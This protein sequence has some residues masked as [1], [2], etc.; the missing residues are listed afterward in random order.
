MKSPASPA[1]PDIEQA[2]ADFLIAL[3][4]EAGLS[5]NTL[6]AYKGDLRA[7]IAWAVERGVLRLTD[8]DRDLI[9]GWLESLR[10][11]GLAPSTVARR[12][13][14]ASVWFAHLIAEG[15]LTLDPTAL[16]RSPRLARALPKSLEVSEVER[17]LA[18]PLTDKSLA[19][20]RRQR[21]AA[22][23]EVLYAAGA[24]VSEATGLCTDGI[25]PALRVLRLQGK[26]RK[27]RLVPCNERARSALEVWMKEGRTTLKGHRQR[28]EVFLT[29][30]GAPL[31]R[32]NA[33]RV[34][35][36]AALAAGVRGEVSPHTLR[37]AFATHL[38]EGGADLRSVQEMLGHASISTT[39][40]YTHVDGEKLLALHRLYHPRA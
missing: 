36:R 23:L 27:V 38:I 10:A 9:Y 29:K 13:S 30:S 2:L 14:A 19:P 11:A 18:A 22:L 25:E 33:W 21:D 26:G 12:L 5:R 4:V 32:S 37:H 8:F 17:L 39:E 31:D 1:A 28:P 7:L 15:K 24:R 34:V 3:R 6:A 20:W 40:I 16:V 35:R